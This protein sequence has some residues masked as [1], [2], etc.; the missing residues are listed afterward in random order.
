MMGPGV[1]VLNR[2]HK[3]EDLKIPMRLQGYHKKDPVVIEDD[4][5]IGTRAIL[6]PGVRVER[7]AVIAASAVVTHN[8]CAFDV[9]AGVPARPIGSRRNEKK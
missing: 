8:V 9:V 6:M 5:W 7:G 4:V 1:V 2:H 3:M